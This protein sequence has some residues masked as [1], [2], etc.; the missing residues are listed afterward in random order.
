MTV[1][2]KGGLTC[3]Q[4]M[5]LNVSGFYASVYNPHPMSRRIMAHIFCSLF[6]QGSASIFMNNSLFNKQPINNL[7]GI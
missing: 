2:R 5:R 6:V 3:I 1:A 7:D 4:R